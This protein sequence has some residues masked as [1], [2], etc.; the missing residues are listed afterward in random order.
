M[1]HCSWF[2]WF[3]SEF[4]IDCWSDSGRCFESWILNL[5]M[6]FKIHFKFIFFTLNVV[7][8]PYWPSKWIFSSSSLLLVFSFSLCL[9][10]SFSNITNTRS[11]WL[12]FHCNVLPKPVGVLTI[13]LNIPDYP[14]GHCLFYGIVY[15]IR[16]ASI[17]SKSY[18]AFN[19]KLSL[20]SSNSKMSL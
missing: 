12:Y 19:R 15:L 7:A 6:L 10:S 11:T 16:L 1:E 4:R 2:V 3:Y 5:N 18:V 20:A 8:F 14:P 17:G 9:S 13:C